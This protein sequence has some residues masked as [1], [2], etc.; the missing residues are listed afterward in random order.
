M[1]VPNMMRNSTRDS[2]CSPSGVVDVISINATT[3]NVTVN[4]SMYHLYEGRAHLTA[5]V[6]NGFFMFVGGKNDTYVLGMD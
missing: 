6:V 4:S 3:R 1:L 5:A 2:P